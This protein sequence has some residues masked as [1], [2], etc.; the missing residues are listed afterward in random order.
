MKKVLIISRKY[1]GEVLGEVQDFV[2]NGY[3]IVFSF[4]AFSIVNDNPILRIKRKL[5]FDISKD[6][7]KY[8]TKYNKRI[9]KLVNKHSPSLVYV[10]QG[11]Q[12]DIDTIETIKKRCPIVVHLIDRLE[13]F[14]EIIQFLKHY[15][16]ILSYSFDDTQILID[17]GLSCFFVPSGVNRRIHY[18]LKC[19]KTIDVSFIGDIYPLRREWLEK[20]AYEEPNV[21]FRFYGKYVRMNNTTAFFRW[22]FDKR[23][24]QCF[25]NRNVSSK[26]A[27]KIYNK[28]KICLNI[29]R[30]NNCNGI[31]ERV[32]KI[33]ATKSFLLMSFSDVLKG[34]ICTDECLFKNYE[35]MRDK[36]R[37]FLENEFERKKLSEFVYSKVFE[38]DGCYSKSI[39]NL[40]EDPK[41][42]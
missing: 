2:K 33:L 15:N 26:K 18:P 34:V 32:S 41:E 42:K 14:P 1:H 37:F 10:V 21:R 12:L 20:L 22:L 19:K 3:E 17:D 35:E 9:I 39:V 38:G 4:S 6:E 5:G 40:I 31:S 8:R 16:K 27:N 36:I 24:R 28:S 23:L 30:E 13:L 29:A 11:L 7:A 25:C